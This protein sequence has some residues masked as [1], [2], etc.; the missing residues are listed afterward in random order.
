M[1][2]STKQRY[3]RTNTIA[4]NADAALLIPVELMLPS[5]TIIV[6]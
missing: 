3:C 5:I 1:F 6:Y 2:L 4:E